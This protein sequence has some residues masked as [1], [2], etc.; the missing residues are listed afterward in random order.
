[1]IGLQ[2]LHRQHRKASTGSAGSWCR[3]DQWSAFNV[4]GQVVARERVGRRPFFLDEA[5]ALVDLLAERNA[6]GAGSLLVRW[7][8]PDGLGLVRGVPRPADRLAICAKRN[9]VAE[10]PL[11]LG[12]SVGAKS[13]HRRAD[14][15]NSAAA[16][17]RGHQALG[18]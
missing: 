1:M 2:A 14:P 7:H 6:Q 3:V 4:L 17:D 15:D 11:A 9:Q 12:V 16:A 8:P 13:P 5:G 10:L 18:F